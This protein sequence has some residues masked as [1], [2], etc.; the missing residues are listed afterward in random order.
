M[1]FKCFCTKTNSLF[2][3]CFLEVLTVP[4]YN[5]HVQRKHLATFGRTKTLRLKF[6]Q[7]FKS[8]APVGTGAMKKKSQSSPDRLLGKGS[9]HGQPRLHL[10][11]DVSQTCRT[12]LSVPRKGI[13]GG[14]ITHLFWLFIANDQWQLPDPFNLPCA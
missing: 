11:K 9:H 6:Q 1:D 8:Y 7:M 14:L 13:K 4:S 12:T 3:P 2:I 10:L 5:F